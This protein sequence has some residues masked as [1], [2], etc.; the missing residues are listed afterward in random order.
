[1]KTPF[2]EKWERDIE[3]YLGTQG[4]QPDGA[5]YMPNW[6]GGECVSLLPSPLRLPLCLR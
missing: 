4:V 6:G 3:E 1:M 5:Q 2:I